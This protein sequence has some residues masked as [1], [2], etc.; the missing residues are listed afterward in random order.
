MDETRTQSIK[1]IALALLLLLGAYLLWKRPP[2]ISVSEMGIFEKSDLEMTEADRLVIAVAEY[3][4]AI[5]IAPTHPAGY[6]H[7]SNAYLI[8]DD[9]DAA[10]GVWLDAIEQNSSRTWPYEELISLFRSE[11]SDK[12]AFLEATQIWSTAARLNPE[13]SWPYERLAQL[14]WQN[15]KLPA[16]IHSFEQ[17]VQREPLNTENYLNLARLHRELHQYTHSNNM[18]IEALQLIPD[19]AN[20]HLEFAQSLYA[21]GKIGRAIARTEAMVGLDPSASIHRAMSQLLNKY[22]TV[23]EQLS[24]YQRVVNTTP[25]DEIARKAIIRVFLSENLCAEA[26]L[27]ITDVVTAYPTVQGYFEIIELANLCGSDSQKLAAYN[28][29]VAIDPSNQ[30]AN[31]ELGVTLLHEDR[32]SGMAHLAAFLA[33]D[34]TDQSIR[35]L[36]GLLTSQLN[37]LEVLEINYQLLEK[38][39]PRELAPY[40]WLADTFTDLGL[41]DEGSRVLQLHISHSPDNYL[42][43]YELAELLSQNGKPESSIKYYETAIS[44]APDEL[45]LKLGLGNAYLQLGQLDQGYKVLQAALDI[46]PS[47]KTYHQLRQIYHDSLKWED[48]Y[49]YQEEIALS[50]FSTPVGAY[51]NLGDWYQSIGDVEPAIHT[52][53]RVLE[54]EPEEYRYYKILSN[55]YLQLSDCRN[56]SRYSTKS[57]QLQSTT[58]GYLELSRVYVGCGLEEAVDA[59]YRLA[60]NSYL[61]KKRTEDSWNNF[62]DNIVFYFQ[63]DLEEEQIVSYLTE[64]MLEN[65]FDRSQPY[66]QLGWY[67]ELED[68]KELAL[69]LYEKTIDIEAGAAK[70]YYLAG[71]LHKELGQ[72]T[73]AISSLQKALLLEPDNAGTYLHLGEAYIQ[74]GEVEDGISMMNRSLQMQDTNWTLAYVSEIYL[75]QFQLDK[76]IEEIISAYKLSSSGNIAAFRGV[77]EH[78]RQKG[79]INRATTMLEEISQHRYGEIWPT[80]L[81]SSIYVEQGESTEAYQALFM[82]SYIDPRT[83]DEW[84]LLGRIQLALGDSNSAINSLEAALKLDKSLAWSH[85]YL[86]EAFINTDDVEGALGNLQNGLHHGLD[87]GFGA[88]L[89]AHVDTLATEHLTPKQAMRLYEDLLVRNPENV[90]ARHYLGIWLDKDIEGDG[91][92]ENN[93]VEAVA[94]P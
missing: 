60:V 70:P 83:A 42:T 45:M 79:A 88:A 44:L 34:K 87:Y 43:H 36:T 31:L 50:F 7:L 53:Q 23:D 84:G 24:S 63:D 71:R 59:T 81:I 39:Q 67:H 35:K 38:A 21:Q 46:A 6:Q 32:S 20:V 77:I 73:A 58:E 47:E 57:A 68:D 49:K 65:D 52:Y 92:E 69:A 5:R 25:H 33:S 17:A 3:K 64:I 74:A 82:T 41:L 30:E 29:I 76:A 78:L 85:I 56:A 2:Y 16:A 55:L 62:V 28:Q 11:R 12:K 14:Q 90:L 26:L 86:G 9:F 48:G 15:A 4:K 75:N 51:E 94:V 54:L 72:S 89:Y 27:Y 22:A 93:A 80:L 37:P 19:N 8:K 10:Y 91:A 1:A 18:Y 40:Q 13:D 66:V 61:E